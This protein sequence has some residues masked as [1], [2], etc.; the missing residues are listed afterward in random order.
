MTRDATETVEWPTARDFRRLI[1]ASLELVRAFGMAR[2]HIMSKLPCSQRATSLAHHRPKVALVCA[3]MVDA[4]KTKGEG[5]SGSESAVVTFEFDAAR[6]PIS[7]VGIGTPPIYDPEANKVGGVLYSPGF[8]AV[9][10][11][12]CEQTCATPRV[13]KTANLRPISMTRHRG[14]D[15]VVHERE[16]YP[17]TIWMP[18]MVNGVAG[19]M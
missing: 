8:T 4:R 16:L 15:G 3:P 12:G 13:V 19:Q 2:R 7:K 11:T 9:W 18:I 10:D 17:A 5:A 1:L 14:V 6:S